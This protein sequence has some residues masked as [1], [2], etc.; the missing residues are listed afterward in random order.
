[1]ISIGGIIGFG[2]AFSWLFGRE[3]SDRTVKDLLAL[4]MSRWRIAGAKLVVAVAWCTVLAVVA[5]GFGCLIAGLFGFEGMAGHVAD[6]FARYLATVSMVVS[7]SLPV[8]WSA[9]A[10]R[11]FMPSLGFVVLTMI[12]AQFSGAMGVAAYFPWAIPSLF[13]GAAG[14]AEMHL[15]AAS[16]AIPYA[17][18]LLGIVGTLAWWRYADQR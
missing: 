7:L 17:V 5:F 18:G 1:M 13:S 12:T 2:F 6:G 8:A 4:P 16:L 9:S 3:Y 10:G 14:V 15:G 11:G